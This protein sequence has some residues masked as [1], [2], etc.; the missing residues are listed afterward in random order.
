MRPQPAVQHVGQH[1][2]DHM[3][4][5]V[6]VDVDQPLPILEVDVGEPLEPVQAGSVDQNGDRAELIADGRERRVHLRP[7][8]HVGGEREGVSRTV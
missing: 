6:E 5:P 4:D 2:L 7:V 1:R 8:G 3:E